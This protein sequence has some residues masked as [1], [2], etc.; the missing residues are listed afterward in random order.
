MTQAATV[1]VLF[2][3]SKFH[4]VHATSGNI[5]LSFNFLYQKS[6]SSESKIG[7]GALLTLIIALSFHSFVEGLGLGASKTGS[8]SIF[9]AIGD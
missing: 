5:T 7:P 9:V 6:Q 4:V 8:T 1:V 2:Q 3:R